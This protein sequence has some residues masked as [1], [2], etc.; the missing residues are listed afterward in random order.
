M[1]KRRAIGGF[2]LWLLAA[3]P[4][5]AA[6]LDVSS[7]TGSPGETVE[8]R[9]TLSQM[10]SGIAGLQN[11]IE[12]DR[13]AAIVG[14]NINPNIGRDLSRCQLRPENCTPGLNCTSLSCVIAGLTLSPIPDGAQLYTCSVRIACDA[15]EG[16][17]PLTIQNLIASTGDPPLQVPI[18]G[19]DG[20]VTVSGQPCP[21]PTPTATAGAADGDGGGGCNCQLGP[22]RPGLHAFLLLLP[23]FV[24]LVLRARRSR[25]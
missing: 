7:A 21:E 23:P 20:V 15:P 12:F 5:G 6:S 14:C 17:Y 2:I 16:N 22:R 8:V 10:G 18:D 4:A 11:V 9:V 13:R 24:L 1:S 25:G 3:A 19:N